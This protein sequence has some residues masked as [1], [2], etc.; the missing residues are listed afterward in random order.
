MRM[1][2]KIAV[3]TG[4]ARG[5]GRA[6]VERYS[7]EGATCAVADIDFE[8]ATRASEAVRS[9]GGKA[10][11]VHLDVTRAESIAAMVETV[12]SKAERIDILVNNAG[13][14]E[15]QPIFEINERI[16]ERVFSVN[17]KGLFF[18]LQAVAKRMVEQNKGGK[19]INL[20]SEAGQRADAMVI[21]YSATKAAVISITKTAAL[22]LIPHRI[23]V[24][25]I[26]PGVVDTPMWEEVDRM[27]GK[28]KGKA[29][30]ETKLET[31]REVPFGRFGSPEDLAGIAVFLAT[32]DSDYMLG[33]TVNV[34]GGR[35]MK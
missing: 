21:A 30:G 27:F 22:A 12:V 3:V 35:V 11:P 34:D 13:V 6:I 1:D 9:F 33:Q 19:I 26:S 23:N 20:A 10:F 2:G 8:G 17:V 28:W 24:N 7:R 25:A 18:T 5:I 4:G 14:V 29:V 16:W 32:A 31:E 15:V